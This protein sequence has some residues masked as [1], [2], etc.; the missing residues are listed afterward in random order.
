MHLLTGLMKKMGSNGLPISNWLVFKW[1]TV[2]KDRPI[3]AS[4]EITLCIAKHG[5]AYLDGE[6][7]KNTFL[8]RLLNAC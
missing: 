6:Y 2:G 7:I 1:V 3:E 5:E 8:K 4:Y